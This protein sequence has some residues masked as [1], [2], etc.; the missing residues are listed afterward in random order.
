ML[1]APPRSPRR[2]R[3]EAMISAARGS[4]GTIRRIA[5][6]RRTAPAGSLASKAEACSMAA[7]REPAGGSGM[8]G[9]AHEYQRHDDAVDRRR[10]GALDLRVAAGAIERFAGQGRHQLH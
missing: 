10:F 7:P 9:L 2:R 3:A 4:V 8:Y 5:S 1:R 6:A